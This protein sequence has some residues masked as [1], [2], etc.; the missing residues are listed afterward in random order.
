MSGTNNK[1]PMLFV[2]HGSPM[3]AIEDNIFT[4]NWEAI[5]KKIPRPEAI[6]AISAHWYTKGTRIS[7]S[8][9]P[10]MVY[11]MYGFPEELYQI[12]YPAKGAPDYAHLTKSLI[13][14]EVQIDNSWGYDHGIWSIL[15]KMYPKADIPVYEFSIDSLIDAES[16]YRMGREISS[17]REKGVLILASGNVVHNL[18]RV[19]FE[20]DGGFLW[21]EEFDSYIKENVLNRD[22][23]EVIHYENA[24]ESSTLAVPTPEHFYPLL[25]ILGASK[26]EDEISVFND[27]C[28][29]GALSMTSYLFQ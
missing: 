3:N 15:H 24:G 14:K 28:T 13:T 19:D 21:A 26:M 18:R 25:Y 12:N 8:I 20:M 17:L 10:K 2:G 29:M 23:K 16:H 5:G 22:Y 27:S 7:D 6:L 11:D 9:Q 4:Q 1:M